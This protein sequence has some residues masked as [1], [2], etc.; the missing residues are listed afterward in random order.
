MLHD[1]ASPANKSL[2]H[3]LPVFHI[4]LVL[5]TLSLLLISGSSAVWAKSGDFSLQNIHADIKQ[6]YPSVSHISAAILVQRMKAEGPDSFLLLDAREKDEFAVSHLPGAI[7]VNPGIWHG[8]FM[9]KFAPLAKGK[10]VVIYCSVGVRSSKLAAYVQ[11]ALKKAG[12]KEVFNLEGGIFNWH[13]E[14]RPLV[15]ASQPTDYVHPYN[16]HWGQL[17]TRADRTSYQPR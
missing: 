1:V 15:R 4:F 12:A 5:L 11:K 13:N 2:F 7:R 9:R 17:V 6:R 10:S 3:I 14:K 16:R 8:P